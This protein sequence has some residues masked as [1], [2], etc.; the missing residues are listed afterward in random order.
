MSLEL[1]GSFLQQAFQPIHN[2][3]RGIAVEIL[4]GQARQLLPL[5]PVGVVPLRQIAEKALKILRRVQHL[6]T[7]PEHFHIDGKTGLLFVF[8]KILPGQP[9]GLSCQQIVENDGRIVRNQRVCL[10]QELISGY[11]VFTV[12]IRRR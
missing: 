1:S 8:L 11:A 7:G 4:V 3:R 10:P 9:D 5:F 2:A 12:I 6:G